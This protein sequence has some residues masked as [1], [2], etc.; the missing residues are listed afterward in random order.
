MQCQQSISAA[1]CM[2]SSFW[3]LSGLV[4][5]QQDSTRV[6][7]APLIALWQYHRKYGILM[8]C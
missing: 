3:Y 8:W 1:G 7:A 4:W 2:G 5:I 6:S